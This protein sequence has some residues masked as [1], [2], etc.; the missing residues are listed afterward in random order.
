MRELKECCELDKNSYSDEGNPEKE[1]DRGE[2]GRMLY[3]MI[4]ELGEPDNEIMI[5]YYY[6]G[7]KIR[8]ISK[9]MD[10][11]ISTVK[12]K[13]KRSRERLKEMLHERSDR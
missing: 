12:T 6:N 1:L 7:E 8:E 4:M 13:L 9:A 11:N 3:G 5:R 2:T 10:I